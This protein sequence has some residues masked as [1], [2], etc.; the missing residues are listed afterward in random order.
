[1]NK[2]RQMAYVINDFRQYSAVIL[3]ATAFPS[4]PLHRAV[5]APEVL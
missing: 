4:V 2:S 5:D 3:I 1:M